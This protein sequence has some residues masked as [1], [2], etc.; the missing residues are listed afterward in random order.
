MAK[1]PEGASTDEKAAHEKAASQAR[2]RPSN[3]MRRELMT[4]VGAAWQ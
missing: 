1:A 3:L 2:H 4:H